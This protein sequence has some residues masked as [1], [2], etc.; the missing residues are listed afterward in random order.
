MECY[1]LDNHG[2]VIVSRN[3]IDT[4][5]FLGE[6]SGR[7]M[8]NL[9]NE[10]IYDEVNVTDYQGVCEDNINEG[11]PASILQT[12]RFSTHILTFI[13]QIIKFYFVCSHLFTF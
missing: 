1:V 13:N 8:Q 6:I 3:P 7:L 10:N 4:G 11:N 9:V 5:K 2:Y 12:V